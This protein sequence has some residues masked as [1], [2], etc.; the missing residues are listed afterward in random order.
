MEYEEAA[1]E[2][3]HNRLANLSPDGRDIFGQVVQHLFQHL[4]Q[5]LDAG[6]TERFRSSVREV[7]ERGS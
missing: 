6:G 4:V 7:S 3:D 1:E 2:E 5:R